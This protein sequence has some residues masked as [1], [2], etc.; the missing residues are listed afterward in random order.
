MSYR[1]I[2]GKPYAVN[3]LSYSFDNVNQNIKNDFKPKEKNFQDILDDVKISKH[4][5]SR[6][7][8]INFSSDDMKEI[9][10]G[11]KIAENK[12]SKN[13]LMLY[14]NVALI[15]SVEN[16]TL[17]TAVDKDRAKENIFTNIDSVVIL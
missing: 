6:L 5:A 8:D 10:K 17:I 1:I 2:N 13:T 15:A 9:E 4:A 7:N 3:E 12:N 14:K 16:R 11:F